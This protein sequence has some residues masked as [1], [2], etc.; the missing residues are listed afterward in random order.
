MEEKI[1]KLIRAIE[2]DLIYNNSMQENARPYLR[3]VLKALKSIIG[4]ENE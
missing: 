3:D 4:E 2:N 1:K